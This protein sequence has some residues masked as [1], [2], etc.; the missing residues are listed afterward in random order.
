MAPGSALGVLGGWALGRWVLAMYADLFRFPGLAFRMSGTLV[1]TAILVSA[2]AAVAGAM[3]A[4]RGAVRLPPAEAMR[5]PAPARYRRGVL[6][7]LGL[8]ALA[9]TS[10]L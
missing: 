9:G 3:L 5:P 1:G 4:V 8:T 7:R 2:V 10:A 6:E